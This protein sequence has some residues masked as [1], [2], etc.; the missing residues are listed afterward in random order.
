MAMSAVINK[1]PID[2]FCVSHAGWG[3][4][5]QQ[6]GMS[7]SKAILAGLVWD[8]F[9]EP[10]LKDKF[11]Q[12]F[13]VATQDSVCN[14]ACDTLATAVGYEIARREFKNFSKTKRRVITGASIVVPCFLVDAFKS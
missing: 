14:I 2:V 11:P 6:M 5:Y 3:M 1:D 4:L 12:A 8:A 13:P 7:L 10:I 9:I